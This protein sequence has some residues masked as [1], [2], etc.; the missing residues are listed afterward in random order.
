MKKFLC[1][2]VLFFVSSLPMFS[3]DMRF[4]QVDGAFY[5]ENSKQKL[6]SLIEKIN[7]EKEVEF[8]VFTGN[9]LSKSNENELKSFL[10]VIK[11]LKKSF[12]I[13]LGQKD[14]NKQGG[15]S[16]QAY[17]QILR[18]NVRTHKKIYSPN[19]TFKKNGIVFIVADGS[20]E[21]IPTAS[22]YYKDDVILWLDEQLDIYAN[23]KIVILQHYP[24]VPPA[25]KETYYTYK[26]DKYLQLLSEHKNV[27][28][29][30][31]GHFGVNKEEMVNGI[32]HISTQNAPTY[33]VIDI[34]DY[35][36]ENPTFWSTIKE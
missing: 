19:Y 2:W 7:K 21:V 5:S 23:K 8:V 22:G 24:L 35:D 34:L 20:K 17:M 27:K 10:K 15:L 29:L 1:F 18:K 31:A 36:T 33:R 28:A 6:E 26:A 14:V 11:N 16:K 13:V 25:Q 12:Y 9:N 4:I 3:A 32:L 30:V